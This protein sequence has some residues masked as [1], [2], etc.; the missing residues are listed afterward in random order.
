LLTPLRLTTAR[1]QVFYAYEQVLSLTNGQMVNRVPPLPPTQPKKKRKKGRR[2]KR[3]E[4]AD[5]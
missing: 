3:K 4:A 5:A 2:E 1:G